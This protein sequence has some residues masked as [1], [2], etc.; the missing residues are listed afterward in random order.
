MKQKQ[1]KVVTWKATTTKGVIVHQVI[2]F[3]YEWIHQL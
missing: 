1:N 2:S 3:D